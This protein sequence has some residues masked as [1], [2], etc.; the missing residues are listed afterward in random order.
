MSC[1]KR[2][3]QFLYGLNCLQNLTRDVQL[4][5]LKTTWSFS[6]LKVLKSRGLP[7]RGIL[8]RFDPFIVTS[9]RFSQPSQSTL[10]K[11]RGDFDKQVDTEDVAM[12]Q[13]LSI[14]NRSHLLQSHC[15]VLTS[16]QT[17]LF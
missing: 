6:F 9:R 14:S 3:V 1:L 13:F 8:F 2:H 10:S 12:S 11:D 4:F 16:S 17:K 7:L 5:N 15:V